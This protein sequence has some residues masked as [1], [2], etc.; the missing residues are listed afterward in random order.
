MYEKM[1]IID[2]RIYKKI[3]RVMFK[4]VVDPAAGKGE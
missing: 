1:K 4:S 2:M 3:K